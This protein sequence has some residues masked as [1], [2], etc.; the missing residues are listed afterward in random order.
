MA[1]DGAKKLNGSVEEPERTCGD[2]YFGQRCILTIAVI[3]LLKLLL[4]YSASDRRDQCI[5][6]LAKH[7][8][9]SDIPNLSSHR[10]LPA[11]LET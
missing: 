5:D 11:V 6:D 10:I 1:I 8:I 3:V 4:R 7:S 2:L 9:S